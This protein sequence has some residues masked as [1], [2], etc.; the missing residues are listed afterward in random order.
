M[1]FPH[2]EAQCKQNGMASIIGL[3]QVLSPVHLDRESV[4]HEGRG[5]VVK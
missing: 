5:F 4:V 2:L 1:N 3:K